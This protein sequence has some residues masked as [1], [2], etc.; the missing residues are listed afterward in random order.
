MTNNPFIEVRVTNT[1]RKRF[2][3]I[4]HSW[5][6]LQ[7]HLGVMTEDELVKLIRWELDTY[8]RIHVLNRVKGRHNRLRDQ[9][10]RNE[11]FTVRV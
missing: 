8:N 11:L 1:D 3:Q 2:E 6:E 4:A 9:R 5:N 10:E 7:N